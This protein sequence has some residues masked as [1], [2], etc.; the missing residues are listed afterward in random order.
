MPRFD[1]IVACWYRVSS[2]SAVS[3]SSNFRL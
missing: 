1:P 2:W 3:F